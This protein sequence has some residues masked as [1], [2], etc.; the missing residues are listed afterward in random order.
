MTHFLTDSVCQESF[1]PRVFA[2]A[3]P[4]FYS[5]F[6]P[7]TQFWLNSHIFEVPV[8][9]ALLKSQAS[10]P[11]QSSSHPYPV[12]FF[13]HSTYYLI[14]CYLIYYISKSLNHN[15]NLY[16]GRD[17]CLLCSQFHPLHQEE[18]L[19]HNRYSVNICWVSGWLI[20]HKRT[21]PHNILSSKKKNKEDKSFCYWQK[22][23]AKCF[24]SVSQN[25]AFAYSFVSNHW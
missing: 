12:A 4:S 22:P 24:L 8:L 18:C 3:I 23:C 2:F 5:V 17:F 6:L 19:V 13:P 14:I 1:Y 21:P 25:F 20:L 10:L 7:D 15:H 11:L 9:T 16:M